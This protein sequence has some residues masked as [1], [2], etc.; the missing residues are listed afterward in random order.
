MRRDFARL[1]TFS[2]G[3]S[4]RAS[5]SVNVLPILNATLH[6]VDIAV[7]HASLSSVHSVLIS[8]QPLLFFDTGYTPVHITHFEA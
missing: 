3:P 5:A 4:L 6:V 1:S 8:V 7:R 2:F